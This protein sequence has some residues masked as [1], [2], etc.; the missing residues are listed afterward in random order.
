MKLST[1]VTYDA[2]F[3]MADPAGQKS[4]D[5]KFLHNHRKKNREVF[6]LCDKRIPAGVSACE[7]RWTKTS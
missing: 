3:L 6:F 2:L 5:L 1:N 7:L 4:H